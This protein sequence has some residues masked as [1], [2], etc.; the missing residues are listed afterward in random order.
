[1]KK[2]CSVYADYLECDLLQGVIICSNSIADIGLKKIDYLRDW[3]AEIGDE[4]VISVDEEALPES[5]NVSA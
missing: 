4:M 2:Q 3:I 1:M 5:K